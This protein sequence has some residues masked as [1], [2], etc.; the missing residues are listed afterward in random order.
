MDAEPGQWPNCRNSGLTVSIH[1]EYGST[2]YEA[3]V[4]AEEVEEL[5]KKIRAPALGPDVGHD[6][7]ILMSDETKAP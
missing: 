2:R 5:L 4:R 7:E 1:C 6:A 3:W